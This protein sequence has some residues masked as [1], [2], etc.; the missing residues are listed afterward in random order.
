MKS[1]Y[2]IEYMQENI[3]K[4]LSIKISEENKIEFCQFRKE[5][6]TI[7]QKNS[8]TKDVIKYPG[9]VEIKKV[10]GSIELL[11]NTEKI[12]EKKNPKAIIKNKGSKNEYKELYDQKTAQQTL[13]SYSM[14]IIN[15]RVEGEK[16]D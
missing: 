15:D 2:L 11:P 4:Q 13:Q 7:L 6:V 5:L 8:N 14:H 1:S 10:D 3:A 9:K 12:I 16:D